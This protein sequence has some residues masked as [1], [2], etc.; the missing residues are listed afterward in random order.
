MSYSSATLYSVR[1]SKLSAEDIAVDWVSNK[2]YWI[3]SLWARI[4]VMDIA[5]GQ[6]AELLRTNNH[7][8]PRGIALDPIAR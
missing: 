6:R 4:E 1:F 7:S 5:S 8:I 2:L 3:D